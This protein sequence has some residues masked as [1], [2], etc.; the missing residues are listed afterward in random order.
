MQPLFEKISPS[1]FT[2][3]H[4]HKAEHPYLA[5]PLHYHP[6]IEIIHVVE[7]FGTRIV[8]ANIRNFEAGDLVMVG[9]GVPHVWRNDEAFYRGDETLRAV[10]R[11]LHFQENLWGETFI[12]LPEMVRIKLLFRQA[13][14]GI[15]FTGEA[16]QKIL[17]FFDQIFAG[18]SSQR[19]ILLI[20]ML[21]YMAELTNM[22]F[23]ESTNYRIL[24]NMSDCERVN[25]VYE[26]LLNH[27]PTNLQ[28]DALAGYV[29][30]SLPSLCRFFRQRTHRSITEVLNDIR[31][32]QACKLLADERLSI[33]EISLLAGYANYSH[34]CEQFRKITGHTPSGYRKGRQLS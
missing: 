9:S 28:F 11:V 23:L 26:Y 18:N 7:S 30:M 24:Y 27:Y 19:L 31:I 2:S 17:G 21:H 6:E 13:I 20:N 5:T 14:R 12:N 4:V 34:F 25:K 8:G 10:V 29:H 15:R 22:E 1:Q 3:F 33:S 32:N 16:G